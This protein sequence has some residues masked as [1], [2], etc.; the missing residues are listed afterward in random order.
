MKSIKLLAFLLFMFVSFNMAAQN[1]F[2]ND[3]KEK[4]EVVFEQNAVDI[5][6]IDEYNTEQDFN[7]K[8]NIEPSYEVYDEHT[9]EIYS[10]EKQPKQ[11]R[12]TLAGEIAAEIVV[13]VIINTVFIIA[14]CW[15]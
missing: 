13:E 9:E 10:D 7:E 1:D 12:S 14:T 6:N 8:Y 15:N 11:R 5:N 4:N 3:K 2:Y